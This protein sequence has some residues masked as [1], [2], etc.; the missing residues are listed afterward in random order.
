MYAIFLARFV[1]DNSEFQG[2]QV[3]FS[4]SKKVSAFQ[5]CLRSIGL[6]PILLV[7]HAGD[8]PAR[9]TAV[10]K[11]GNCICIIPAS[12]AILR[13]RM[14]QYLFGLV[15][16]SVV[17]YKLRKRRFISLFFSWDFLPDTLLP[18]LLQGRKT[19]NRTIVDIEESIS[20]DPLAG[21]FFKIFERVAI[22]YFH[23][24][25]IGNNVSTSYS[26]GVKLEGI[27]QGFFANSIREE[28]EMLIRT[29]RKSFDNE[30]VIFF[31]G[32][33]DNVRGARQFIEL[34]RHF[35]K[36]EGICFVMTG[37]GDENEI[38]NI[39]NNLPSNIFFKPNLRRSE[40]INLLFDSD[41]AFNFISDS[42]FAINSFPSKVVEY[43]LGAVVVV[44]N[45]EVDIDSERVVFC[46]DL[47]QIKKF[48]FDYKNNK[49]MWR[50]KYNSKT[51]KEELDKFS[52]ANCSTILSKLINE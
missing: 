40:Y 13:N 39:A 20:A 37:Y 48:I 49:V 14:L 41:I 5:S 18:L 30:I 34:A 4:T 51:V 23:L 50:A 27:F 22:R 16:S 3:N 29:E 42:K 31:A 19:L 35:E 1:G 15:Y 47:D 33:I 10:R 46:R 45:H 9:P 43:L 32:R 21:N 38:K 26:L 44:S 12:T 25:A 17:I 7:T 52:I 2:F 11:I 36:E 28:Y 24:R 8:I 6:R